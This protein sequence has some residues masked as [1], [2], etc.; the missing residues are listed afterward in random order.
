VR[1]ARPAAPRRLALLLAAVALAATPGGAAEPVAAEEPAA[2]ALSIES[3][4]VEPAVLAVDT[5]CRLHVT[6]RNA[7]TQT[8]S[9]FAFRVTLNGQE[10]PVYRNQL[11][12][13][14]LAAGATSELRL[15]NFWTTETSRPFPAD[16]RLNVE[17]S[18]VE[19]AW[20]HVAIEDGVEV[21]T[22]RGAV[23]SLPA[24]A[25]VELTLR[26]PAG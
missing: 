26:R 21:W 18:L 15:Y 14:P 5:L 4:R 8:A 25:K 11:F 16:G 3:I 17:V 12:Y 20:M 2:P 24:A 22:P 10:L 7:G 23:E 13:F 6:L 1:E 19:A 9:A